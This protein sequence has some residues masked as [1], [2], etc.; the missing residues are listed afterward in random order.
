MIAYV[1]LNTTVQKAFI[2]GI[3]GCT[4]HHVKLLSVIEEAR[5]KHKSL[6]VCW[7]DVTNA[8]GSVLWQGVRPSALSVWANHPFHW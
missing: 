8:F 1:Y 3:S 5:W 7:L 4:E 2:D 6:A